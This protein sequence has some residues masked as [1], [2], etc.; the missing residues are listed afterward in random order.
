MCELFLPPGLTWI[1]VKACFHHGI[2]NIIASLNLTTS[3]TFS[4]DSVFT[5]HN[6][7]F[8]FRKGE[9]KR[10]LNVLRYK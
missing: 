7:D 9:K 4:G 5:S 10:I 6:L 8:V 2:K 1:C 3:R